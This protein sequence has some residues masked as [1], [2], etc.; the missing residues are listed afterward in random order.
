M[1]RLTVRRLE[2]TRRKLLIK[3]FDELNVLNEIDALYAALDEDNRKAYRELFVA[4]YIEMYVFVTGKKAPDEDEIDDLVDMY[5]AGLLDEPNA[6]THYTYDTEVYRKRDRAKEAINAVPTKAQNQL[7]MEKAIRFWT[8]QT[9]FYVDLVSDEAATKAMID[10]GVKH[11]KWNDQDDKK[12]CSAC[13]DMNGVIY[14]I[15]KVPDK[16]HPRCRCY[17]TPID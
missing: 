9:G 11:V 1:N 16:P 6:V 8:Q 13:H 3:G 15:K 5:L 2:Q 10:G 14:P 17:L 4:R 12:V 7:E